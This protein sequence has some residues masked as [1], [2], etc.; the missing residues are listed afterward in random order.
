METKYQWPADKLT[1][2]EM[3]I[4]YRWREKTKTPINHLLQQV[5]IEMEKIIKG[6]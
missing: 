2:E 1:N 6:G 3:A 4:L 5:I